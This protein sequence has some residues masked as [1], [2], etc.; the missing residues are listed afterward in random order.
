VGEKRAP[1]A[2]NQR[3]ERGIGGGAPA[4]R[5][6]RRVRGG[7]YRVW[8]HAVGHHVAGAVVPDRWALWQR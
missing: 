5:V 8:H 3:R 1:A 7:W 6:E 4:H 2:F